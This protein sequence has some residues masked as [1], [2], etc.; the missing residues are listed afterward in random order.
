M[1][2]WRWSSHHGCSFLQKASPESRGLQHKF[3][4]S[5]WHGNS[6]NLS[7]K[8]ESCSMCLAAL[9]A[10]SAWAQHQGTGIGWTPVPWTT[11]AAAGELLSTGGSIKSVVATCPA[12]RDMAA[13]DSWGGFHSFG[14]MKGGQHRLFPWERATAVQPGKLPLPSASTISRSPELCKRFCSISLHGYHVSSW[15]NCCDNWGE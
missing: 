12:V 5:S 14:W 3:S 7:A 2:G 10:T 6:G 11:S 15:V 9:R 1:R 13:R 4:Y 8:T